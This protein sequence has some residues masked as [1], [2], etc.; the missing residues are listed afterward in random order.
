MKSALSDRKSLKYNGPRLKPLPP[1]MEKPSS[2][3]YVRK[4]NLVLDKKSNYWK[5]FSLGIGVKGG[6]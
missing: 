3:R 2:G 6:N 4:E 5:Q 1:A